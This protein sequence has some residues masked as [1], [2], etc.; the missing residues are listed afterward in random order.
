[1][2]DKTPAK[3]PSAWLGILRKN[4]RKATMV[5]LSCRASPNGPWIGVQSWHVA[6]VLSSDGTPTQRRGELDELAQTAWARAVEYIDEVAE[7]P[8]DRMDFQLEAWGE[9]DDGEVRLLE[10]CTKGG[11]IRSGGTGSEDVDGGGEEH[12]SLVR[13]LL[14]DR[15]EIMRIFLELLKAAPQLVSDTSKLWSEANTAYR[16]Q[17]DSNSAEAKAKAD[18]ETDRLKIEVAA[19]LGERLLDKIGQ[20]KE[21]SDAAKRADANLK[22]DSFEEAA[23][24]LGESISAATA[25]RLEGVNADWRGVIAL[26]LKAGSFDGWEVAVRSFLVELRGQ[27]AALDSMRADERRLLKQLYK[28]AGL[29]ETSGTPAPPANA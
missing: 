24:M 28:C 23:R 14:A 12:S 17:Y 25:M 1:M 21:L 26:L 20:D 6:D 3:C 11:R 27:S 2:S 22:I 15:K 10:S 8:G 7:A 13:I 29:S 16:N 18:A 4:A 19:R 5:S 9:G